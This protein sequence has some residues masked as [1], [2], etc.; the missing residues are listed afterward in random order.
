MNDNQYKVIYPDSES[1]PMPLEQ[2]E[3]RA[4]TYAD[5]TGLNY[6]SVRGTRTKH[7]I[8]TTLLIVYQFDKLDGTKPE[9]IAKVVR[10]H[11]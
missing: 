3:K 5:E 10:I 7:G 4:E 11:E 6:H 9:F 8:T 1:E 2:A